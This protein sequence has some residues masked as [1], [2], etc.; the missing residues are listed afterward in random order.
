[1]IKILGMALLVSSTAMAQTATT[2]TAEKKQ[3]TKSKY[4]SLGPVIGMG[5]SWV[6]NN[7]NN[8]KPSAQ[9][10]IGVLYSRYEHWGFGGILAASH[11]GF[12]DEYYQYGNT[13]R[14]AFDPTYV[15]LTPRAYYFFGKYTSNVRPKVFLGPSVAY[16]VAEDRYSNMET[17]S[18]P[19]G[20]IIRNTGGDRF[21]PWDFGVNAGAGV[22][23][24]VGKYTWL[25]LDADYYHGLLNVTN[26]NTG[27]NRSLRANVGVMIGI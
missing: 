16:K 9:L 23:V 17:I 1:M 26:N 19:E 7:V 24:K 14:N 20:T 13:Y 2:K 27:M 10:G 15:R 8:F 22:N 3:P 6:S 5:H 18:G 21:E 4:T 11:E 25:N 12:A